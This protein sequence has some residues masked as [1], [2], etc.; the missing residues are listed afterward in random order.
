MKV[1][2]RPLLALPAIVFASV[3][4]LVAATV[5]VAAWFAAV[6]STRVP[7]GLAELGNYC[8]RFASQS[9]AYALLLT[10]TS[11]S[12]AGGAEGGVVTAA[13]GSV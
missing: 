9:V 13:S 4:V 7:P 11:P 8:L 1:L 12:L 6:A 10:G 2:L 5:A 3:L